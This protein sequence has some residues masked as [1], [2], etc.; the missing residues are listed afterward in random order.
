MSKDDDQEWAEAARTILLVLS[1]NDSIVTHVL[2]GLLQ[3]FPPG[4][5]TPPSKSITLTLSAI[6]QCNASGFVPFLTDILS[7]TVPLL[8]HLKGEQAR[9]IWARGITSFCEAIIEHSSQETN[10]NNQPT[11]LP[12]VS[13]QMR[14]DYCDQMELVLDSL[15][16]WLN[17]KDPKCR[18]D[19]FE[20]VGS[21]I[22]LVSQER[23]LKEL[24]KIVTSF[25]QLYKKGSLEDQ[26]SMTKGICN[27]LLRT[28][29][30]DSTPVEFYL[31]DI[32]NS[33]FQHVAVHND[34]CKLDLIVIKSELFFS[35]RSGKID[36]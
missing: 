29:S 26:Y 34:Q 12:H 24:K 1:K 6:A 5:S 14:K 9:G 3:K 19:A 27:F 33:L 7:R 4:V 30:D 28:C 32:C 15:M 18:A 17:A 20:A 21:L 10:D 23:V 8:S 36:S 16:P 25:L 13:E 31:D 35:G 11:L 22:M 2:D